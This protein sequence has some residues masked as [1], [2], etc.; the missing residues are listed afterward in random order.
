MDDVDDRAL[1]QQI[2]IPGVLTDLGPTLPRRLIGH[3][4]ADRVAKIL[5]DH[6][7]MRRVPGDRRGHLHRAILLVEDPRPLDFDL[8]EEGLEGERSRPPPLDASAG[9]AMPLV[10]DQFLVGFLDEDPEEEP[11]EFEAGVMDVGLDL[12]GKML[13]LGRDGQGHLECQ[14]DRER[15]ITHVDGAASDGSLKSVGGAHGG[16]PYWN[17]GESSCVPFYQLCRESHPPEF[18]DCP[19]NTRPS[20]VFSLYSSGER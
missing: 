20:C 3:L 8:A 19:K 10:E 5:G 1:S 14:L 13:V 15:P 17:Y 6:Q 12:V 7:L 9:F 11:L 2:V 4:I 16:S 18:K